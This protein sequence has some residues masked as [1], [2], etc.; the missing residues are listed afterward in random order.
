MQLALHPPEPLGL[1]EV[2]RKPR[3]MPR[4]DFPAGALE[5]AQVERQLADEDVAAVIGKSRKTWQRYRRGN[6]CH[7]DV[8][9]RVMEL[10]G[11]EPV[12][13]LRRVPSGAEMD[14]LS[15]QLREVQDALAEQIA[16]NARLAARL[17]QLE[18]RQDRDG[19]SQP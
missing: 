10:L 8:A 14:R 16:A 9:G 7:E 2:T 17:D 3:R 18:L 13:P 15:A 6:Y 4:L 5:A 12:R 19:D 1:D 11:V